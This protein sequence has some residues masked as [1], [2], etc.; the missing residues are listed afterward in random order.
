MI[1]AGNSGGVKTIEDK[2]K[3]EH[4]VVYLPYGLRG[5]STNGSIFRLGLNSNMRGTGIE[6]REITTFLNTL[7]PLL[8]P[9][10]ELSSE[11]EHE[12][13]KFIPM[14]ILN[15]PNFHGINYSKERGHFHFRHGY[16]TELA[17]EELP[18]E[19]ILM[20]AS[21]HFDIF[22]LISKGLA[23]SNSVKK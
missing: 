22:G 16:Q 1:E 15:G 14:D 21:W 23:V 5:V 9:I 13:K 18:Y 3:L 4:L 8:R 7:K 12:G 20:L 19:T 2:L 6:D 10:S 17:I 11:I